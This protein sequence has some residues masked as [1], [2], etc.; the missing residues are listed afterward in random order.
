MKRINP[1][2]QTR[3]SS[4]NLNLS[5]KDWKNI[6]DGGVWELRQG[7]DF[8]GST[9]GAS[10]LVRAVLEARMGAWRISEDKKNGTLTIS[11]KAPHA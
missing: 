7:E 1:E 10:A 8:D 6:L 11:I 3:R 4:I 9:S 5:E 2:K